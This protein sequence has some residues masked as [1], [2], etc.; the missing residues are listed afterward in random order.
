MATSSAHESCGISGRR[1]WSAPSEIKLK[2][3]GTKVLNLL[4]HQAVSGMLPPLR[5]LCEVISKQTAFFLAA[6]LFSSFPN[7][8]HLSCPCQEHHRRPVLHSCSSHRPTE[9]S[10]P[11][12]LCALTKDVIRLSPTLPC[13][14]SGSSTFPFL[15]PPTA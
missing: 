6:F 9:N 5:G 8:R 3:A 12:R 15:L 4:L 10:Q 14:E 7:I 2:S 11:S 13:L 1:V